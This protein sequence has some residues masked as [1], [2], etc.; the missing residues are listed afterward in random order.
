MPP[1]KSVNMSEKEA[2]LWDELPSGMRSEIFKI[3]FDTW[4]EQSVPKGNKW[5]LQQR[6]ADLEKRACILE[7]KY[8]KAENEFMEVYDEISLIEYELSKFDSRKMHNNGELKSPDPEQ[9]FSTFFVHAHKYHEEGK[10][11]RSP[12]GQNRYRVQGIDR[13]KEKIFIER[14]D[15]KSP[16]PSSFTSKTVRKAVRRLTGSRLE[17]GEFMPVLAQECAVVEIHPDMRIL[18]GKIVWEGQRVVE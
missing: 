12:S 18:D 17:V 3:A 11:F 9:F 14:I 8:A 15:S 5:E 1:T 6:L 13:E 16:K 4:A 2:L 7:E 10:I